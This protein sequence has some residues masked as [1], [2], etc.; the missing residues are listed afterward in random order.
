MDRLCG[1]GTES[2]DLYKVVKSAFKQSTE[3][4]A[5][6]DQEFIKWLEEWLRP[7]DNSDLNDAIADAVA[8]SENRSAPPCQGGVAR[9][10][11]AQR[12]SGRA[13]FPTST[14]LKSAFIN[15]RPPHRR[16]P[17]PDELI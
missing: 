15:T 8:P 6:T 16:G 9:N 13:G 10:A 5:I 3:G 7:P 14:S 1:E 12:R 17:R 2:L 4:H 11:L